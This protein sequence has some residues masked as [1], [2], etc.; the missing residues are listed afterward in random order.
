MRHGGYLRHSRRSEVQAGRD[1]HSAQSHHLEGI[2]DHEPAHRPALDA[3]DG[4]PKV[5]EAHV[6]HQWTISVAKPTTIAGSS[7]AFRIAWGC[8]DGQ[9]THCPSTSS[10]STPSTRR[11]SWP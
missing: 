8:D 4:D 11:T 10:Y 6:R 2:A 5:V 1:T 3:L 9:T 7:E